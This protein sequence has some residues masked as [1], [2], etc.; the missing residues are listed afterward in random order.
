MLSDLI[1]SHQLL[2]MKIRCIIPMCNICYSNEH[3]VYCPLSNYWIPPSGLRVQRCFFFLT[4]ACKTVI[5][6]IAFSCDFS[7][8]DVLSPNLSSSASLL[9]LDSN[10][11][12]SSCLK[13]ILGCPAGTCYRSAS[14]TRAPIAK[15]WLL[16]PENIKFLSIDGWS[17]I[18]IWRVSG[19]LSVLPSGKGVLMSYLCEPEQYGHINEG[20]VIVPWLCTCWSIGIV[21]K[22]TYIL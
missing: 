15:A 11:C 13:V 22:S 3:Y 20:L 21:R 18:S 9:T 10:T 12:L 2:T 14:E 8:W 7:Y 1:S 5:V 19:K 16:S 6:W 17:L 4:S